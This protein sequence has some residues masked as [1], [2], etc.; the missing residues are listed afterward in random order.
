VEPIV[1]PLLKKVIDNSRLQQNKRVG[2]MM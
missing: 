2:E 1:L